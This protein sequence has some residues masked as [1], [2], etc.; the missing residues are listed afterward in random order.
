M[1]VVVIGG[2]WAGCA[3]AIS[4]KKAGADVSIF[5]KTDLL[6]GLGNVGGIMRNNGRFT[7]SE[8]LIALGAGDLIN[9]T[10]EN[11]R[12]KNIDFPGHKHAWLYD[13]NKIEPAVKNHMKDMGID[14]HL[15]SRIVD[16]E[17][18]GDKIKGI[19]ISDGTYVDGDVFIETTGST[20]PMGNCLRYG[21]GC[22]MCILRCPAFGPRVSLTSRAGIE[23]FQGEREDDLLGAFSG[24][25]KLAKET[26]SEELI[27]ELDETGVL[28]LKVP[29]EDINLDKLKMKVCQQ[30][31]LKEFAE[32][33]VILDTGHAKLMTSYYPLEKLRK[34]KGLENV[35][36]IDPYAG[37]KGNSIRYLSVAPRTDD[38]KVKGLENL[39]VGG[40][41]SG[42]FV[43]HT[44]A[45]TTGSLA[46]HNA[47]R[48]CLGMPML[49]LPRSIALG[50]LIAYANLKLYSKEGRKNRYTFAG[51]EYFKKMV[52][53]NLYTT[54]KEEIRK[55]VSKLNLEDALA[56][57]LI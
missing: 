57:K 46:G 43:G 47:V 34:I 20:G 9:I 24:S 25:C 56:Q 10:D 38:M 40:E 26:M 28:V 1:K 16:V 33:I 3:A 2:G 4:A 11:S 50:D 31:A 6:L 21:N 44:E 14:I 32:N 19:Y 53:E 12:H 29:K 42:L 49:I 48:H 7:A 30:Y 41:K 17:K 27:K 55:R 39:F 5:E 35:K 37:G 13:V 54:D 51:A 22:S 15:I 23:D 36:Y 8:E 45:I 18:E 52:E